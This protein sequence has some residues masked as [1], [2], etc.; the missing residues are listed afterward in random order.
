[1][2]RWVRSSSCSRRGVSVHNRQTHT[3]KAARLIAHRGVN[4][5]RLHTLVFFLRMML[6]AST[7]RSRS[8]GQVH[9]LKR[10]ISRNESHHAETPVMTSLPGRSTGQMVTCWSSPSRTTTATAPSSRYTNMSDAYTPLETYPSYWSVCVCQQ[11]P[12]MLIIQPT[13]FY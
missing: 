1:M 7:A 12:T 13:A 2:V 11:N 10:L 8:T 3:A 6:K 4:P 9:P 5:S